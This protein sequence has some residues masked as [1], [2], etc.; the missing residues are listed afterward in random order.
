MKPSEALQALA[1]ALLADDEIRKHTLG[2]VHIDYPGDPERDLEYKPNNSHAFLYFGPATYQPLA[3]CGD[4]QCRVRIYAVSFDAARLQ[5]HDLIRAAIGALDQR[6][7][8]SLED[9]FVAFVAGGDVIE[10]FSPKSA[11]ADF[12]FII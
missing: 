3:H 11:Y 7:G 5:A 4:I 6:F 12:Q 9:P 8:A 10:P 2:E 1:T